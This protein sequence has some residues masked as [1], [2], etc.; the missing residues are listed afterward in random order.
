MK[1]RF[2]ITGTCIPVHHYMADISGKIDKLVQ[3]VEDGDYLSVNRPHQ[4]GKTTVFYLLEKRLNA[5]NNYL[6]IDI[7]FE[8]IDSPTYDSHQSFISTVIDLMEQRLSDMGEKELA[9]LL[10]KD[11]NIASFNG[12]STLY[13]QLAEASGRKVVLMIDEVDKSANN[14]LF[15]DF[16]GMLRAKYLK[17]NEGKDKTFQSVILAGV[18]DIKT[19]KPKIRPDD[20]KTYN[21]PWNIAVNFKIDLALSAGEI[22][23]MLR[24][25]ASRENV[26]LDV[27]YFADQLFYYTSGYPFLVSYLCKIIDEELLPG[28]DKKEWEPRD[29]L[30]AVKTA[31]AEECTNFESLVKNLENNPE[32]YDFVF[33]IIMN[34]SEFSYNPRNP[35]IHLGTIYGILKK[36]LGKTCIHNRIFICLIQSTPIVYP[37]NS[38][39][40]VGLPAAF[41]F[42]K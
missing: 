4:F 35:V 36:E 30:E 21:S 6:A 32:L 23:T 28:K 19:L 37:Q 16:L 13:R 31:L 18:H 8:G 1:K 2:N 11:Q 40:P 20:Q 27:P 25:Y 12:L 38:L 41:L 14:Q 42:G 26:T 39:L 22:T 29:L 34:E 17:R 5:D 7:S 9:A 33:Q 24:D 15:L 3:M 10:K